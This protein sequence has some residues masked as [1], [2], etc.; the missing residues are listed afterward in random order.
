M[1]KLIGF[2]FASMVVVILATAINVFVDQEEALGADAFD[3]VTTYCNDT[4]ATSTLS[5]LTT[6][7]ASTTCLVK[8]QGADRADVKWLVNAS[9]TATRLQYV[10]YFADENGNART[11]YAEKN[12]T[13]AI[14]TITY[15]ARNV[16]RSFTPAIAGTTYHNHGITDLNDRWMKVEYKLTGAN[17]GVYLE[18]LTKNKSTLY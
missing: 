14:N 6:S 8:V 9:S 1:K 17:G 10:L 16:I 11:W 12:S 15:S 7:S 13:N 5:Y 3:Q 2:L 4:A 18:V